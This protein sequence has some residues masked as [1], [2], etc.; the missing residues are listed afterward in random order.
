MSRHRV[1]A[2]PGRAPRKD[3]RRPWFQAMLMVIVT[4]LVGTAAL[5]AYASSDATPENGD[6]GVALAVQTLT[7][8]SATATVPSAARE[9]YSVVQSSVALDSTQS[10]YVS[11][12][13]KALAAK[14]MGAVAAGRLVG[15]TPNH[16]PEIQY[17]AEGRVVP[18]CG[19]D[20]RVLQTIDV[21]LNTFGSVG[22]SDINRRCT[23]QILGAGAASS[24]Y[25]DG[26]GHAVD[27]YLLDGRALT[28]GDAQSVKLIRALDPIVPSGAGLGQ[29]GCRAS[30]ALQNFAPFPDTCN[31]L[32]VDFGNA[33]GATLKE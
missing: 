5:P 25:A 21:A 27:F 32:H 10:G 24:H 3:S 16:I 33:T 9:D 20:Y 6:V 15:Y 28:G 2:V 22:V 23:G 14:L 31:H 26:G 29:V 11:T 13:V 19:I 17:L 30:M 7:S 1:S 4:G 18:N 12:T 8:G